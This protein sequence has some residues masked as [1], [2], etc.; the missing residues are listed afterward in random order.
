LYYKAC[1]KHF[2]I[3]LYITKLAQILPNTTIYYKIYKKN[4]NIYVFYKISTKYFTI[5]FYIIL[6]IQIIPNIILYPKISKCYFI[7]QNLHKIYSNI[8]LYFNICTKSFPILLCTTRYPN[9]ILY[10][11]IYTKHYSIHN[12]FLPTINIYIQITFTQY[13]YTWQ[14]FTH[15][16]IFIQKHFCTQRRFYSQQIFT[17]IFFICNNFLKHFF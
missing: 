10:Y 3:L 7:L 8:I 12:K 16:E 5:L 9:T 6:F 13:F 14:S 11:K 2:P 4:P 15:T 17:H 1:T